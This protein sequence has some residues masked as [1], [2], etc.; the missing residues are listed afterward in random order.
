VEQLALPKIQ[1]DVEIIESNE[2]VHAIAAFYAQSSSNQGGVD[3]DSNALFENITF[4]PKLGLAME[5]MMEGMTLDQL[6]R[7]I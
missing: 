6:W 1:E 5:T 2:D 4:D 3:D 7:V